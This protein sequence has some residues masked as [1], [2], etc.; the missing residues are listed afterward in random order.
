MKVFTVAAAK[1]SF[2]KKFVIS[3]LLIFVIGGSI[4]GAWD[5]FYPSMKEVFS[6]AQNDCV[7]KPSANPEQSSMLGSVV[8]YLH[9]A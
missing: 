9:K 2:F 1:K 7:I 8:A 3:V 6:N 4:V 5:Y